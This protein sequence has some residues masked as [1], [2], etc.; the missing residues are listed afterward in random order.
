MV[1]IL[2]FF[3]K[4]LH[5]FLALEADAITAITVASCAHNKEREAILNA[6]KIAEVKAR[7][8]DESRATVY[9]YAYD[10]FTVMKTQ[11]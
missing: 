9:S 11:T 8:I 3:I 4:Q 10:K 1:Q 7:I 5:L 6:C 2:A